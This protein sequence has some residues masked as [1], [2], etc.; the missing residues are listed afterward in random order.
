[1]FLNLKKKLKVGWD[2]SLDEPTY[3]VFDTNVYCTKKENHALCQENLDSDFEFEDT[4]HCL[5]KMRLFL[6][7]LANKN[8]NVCGNC[9]SHLYLNNLNEDGEYESCND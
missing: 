3:H 4:C 6:A 1:M 9:V 2:S 7:K 5:E 8:N